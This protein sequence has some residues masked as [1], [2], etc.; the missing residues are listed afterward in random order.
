LYH[1]LVSL[2]S[3]FHT[4]ARD[5][6]QGRKGWFDDL[7]ANT[8]GW[9]RTVW[10]H[11]ASLGEFEQGRPL[12]EEIRERDPE[13]K[14]LLTFFSPSGYRIRKDYPQADYVTYLPLDTPRN[15]RKFVEQVH[16]EKV[17]FIKYEYWYF[18]L[19]QLH[20]QNIPLYLVSAI[21]RKDQ[22]FFRWYGGWFRHMLNF[23]HHLFV[24]DERSGDLLKTYGIDSVTVSG[25]TR[26]DR[27]QKIV[28]GAPAVPFVEQFRG[29]SLLLVGGS[30]WPSDEELLIRYYQETDTS[31]K[32]LLAPHEVHRQ[33][34]RRILSRFRPEEVMVWSE[35][36]DEDPAQA[37][38]LIIDTI[39]ML[40]SLYGYGKLAYVG[41]GFGKGIHN[42]LEAA[43][44]GIPVVFGP[45]HQ[46]FR[47]A[48]DLIEKGG[49][50]SVQ[51]FASFKK[52]MDSF[53]TEPRQMDEAGAIA[54]SYVKSHAGAT[55]RI[56]SKI[57]Y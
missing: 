23:Y 40:S 24:Q 49:A 12:L 30:T 27:V 10:F 52:R 20:R 44:Y 34:I 31:L 15:A 56:L 28:A 38:V 3:L 33:N 19:R 16:P 46:K 18:M 5:F 47:E 7:Q 17:F 4:K 13:V 25:D 8:A 6:I 48:N 42:I 45:R 9:E 57:S 51:D 11:C 21:F 37:R 55:R 43:T 32:L 41:G 2:A 36:V 35:V 50:F 39:G 14:I 26:F 1:L 22:L 54:G 29:D 53:L